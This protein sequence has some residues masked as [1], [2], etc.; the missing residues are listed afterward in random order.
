MAKAATAPATRTSTVRKSHFISWRA[1]STLRGFRRL[2][3]QKTDEIPRQREDDANGD[4]NC[5]YLPPSQVGGQDLT[6]EAPDS[7]L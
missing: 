2:E 6:E 3:G 1:D 7:F 5:A 4:E